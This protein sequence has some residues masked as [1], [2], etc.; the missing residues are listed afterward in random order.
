MLPTPL[1][2]AEHAHHVAAA[3]ILSAI[4]ELGIA[5]EL[6]AAPRS[7]RE[8]AAS[9]H[10][11]P[12]AVHRLLRAGATFDFV[13]LDRHGRF[14]PTRATRV[15]RSDHPSATADWCRNVT[16][17]AQQAAWAELAGSVRTGD[18]AFRRV[19]GMSLFE[20]FDA[21]PDEGTHFSA[22]LGGLTLAEA[23][24]IIAGYPFPKQG[25][26]CDIAGGRGVLLAEI[27][28]SRPALSG[29]LVESPDV[30]EQ[31]REYL[32]HQGVADR[33]EL[34]A[35]DIF[36][37]LHATADLYVLKWILHDWDDAA[38]QKIL[39]NVANAMPAG[40]RLLTI[41]GEQDR[42]R[43]HPRFS[44]IDLVMLVLT[45]GGRERSRDQL[46]QLVSSSGLT[47]GPVRRSATDLLL[48]EAGKT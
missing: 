13:R 31:A 34:V 11:D 24:A 9:L 27:L 40:A 44:M 33:V 38:C 10:C 26:V 8:L 47:P 43:V 25:T 16:G 42:T 37:G 12:D 19:H 5:D 39:G 21:H 3:H 23:P 22:G 7:A 14:H 2:V 41:E 17:Q 15:L 28:K 36:D 32:H 45:E 4:A 46:S 6:C 35:G 29:V 1:A 18:G 20:W 30:L 48:L